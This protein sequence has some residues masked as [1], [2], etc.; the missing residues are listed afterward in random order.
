[1]KKIDNSIETVRGVACILL[2]IYHVVGESAS[3][4]L[5]VSDDSIIRYLNDSLAYIRMPLFTFLSGYVYALRPFDVNAS[6][7]RFLKGKARRL[8]FPMLSVG[9]VFAIVQSLTPGA[10]QGLSGHDWFLIHIIPVAHFWYLESLFLIFLALLPLEKFGMLDNF[11]RYLVV[12]VVFSLISVAEEYPKYLGLSGAT[13]LMPF[14]LFGMASKRYN[15]YESKK[16]LFLSVFVFIATFTLAQ[17]GLL[18]VISRV[19]K[20]SLVSIFLGCS[21]CFLVVKCRFYNKSLIRIGAY[22]YSVY[23]FHVFGTAASRIVL[24]KSGFDNVFILM[25]LGT[26]WGISLP[27]LCEK[28]ILKTH[29]I[30]KTA[31]LGRTFVFSAK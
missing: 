31:L 9:T 26:F 25:F 29:V 20:C 15:L 17:S 30:F 27:I 5:R 6:V 13:Y 8:L 18:G 11:N 4:G 10:N 23:L 21:F 2:V 1:M 14:F 7:N 28:I 22:S 12:M 24:E 16:F 19:P 3:S